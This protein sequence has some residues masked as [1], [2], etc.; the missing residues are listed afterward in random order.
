MTTAT[1]KKPVAKKA[2]NPAPHRYLLSE[3]DQVLK[4][5]KKYAKHTGQTEAA[6]KRHV[7]QGTIKSMKLSGEVFIILE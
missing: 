6:I 7:K 3:L 2:A 4:T 5:V 1:A